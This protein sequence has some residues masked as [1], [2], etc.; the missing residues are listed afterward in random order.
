MTEL[1]KLIKKYGQPD[2]LVDHWDETS[3]RY[4]IWEFDEEFLINNNGVAILNG[5]PINGMP[6]QIWQDTLD[7]WKKDEAELTAVGYIS[8]DLKNILFP[9]IKFKRQEKIDP[10]LWFGKPRNIIPYKMI[11]PNPKKNKLE[12]KLQHDL[13]YPQEYANN[14]GEIKGYLEKGDSYQINFTQPKQYQVPGNPFD[15]YMSMREYIQPYCGMYL[16]PGN[17][18]ILSFSPERFIRTSN[19]II[20]SFPMKGTR[21]RAEDI[22]QD[23]HLAGELYNSEKDRAE[24]LM[25]V[26][27][28]RN[29]IG[30]VC[31]YGSVNVENLYG[32]ESFETV[33]QM[34][35]R[36]HGKL[37]NNIQET[38]ILHALFP[39]GS[40][41]GAP[42]E[43][44]MKIIDSL[45]N[46]QR[47]IYTGS[48]GSILSNGD[49]DFNIA[50]RTM[51]IDDT[52]G[53]YP[54]G[55]GIVWDSDP[56]EE[57]LEAQQTSKIIDMYMNNIIK[58]NSE[59][60]S[61]LII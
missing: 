33:H 49:M 24:H 61:R 21:P 11:G 38:D 42:K 51:S 22:I 9:H 27:L 5:M 34:V 32:I 48:L 29:D 18:Q 23:K 37:N 41:T 40:I 4:A 39:G 13:P 19:G 17:M 43:R 31:E 58:S 60:E 53:T 47:G 10:L 14:I 57:W 16:N 7:K 8:Y 15:L 52:V 59:L 3:R 26:D 56:L 46:Y 2:A 35:S 55:G 44:S 12:L 50:I 36:V 1:G 6:M 28:I 25:I 30:K 54:V 20:E 45:E